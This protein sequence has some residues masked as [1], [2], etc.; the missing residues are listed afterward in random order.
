[1][2][3]EHP[4]IL[5]KYCSCDECGTYFGTRHLLKVH[6]EK[7]HSHDIQVEHLIESKS[8]ISKYDCKFYPAKFKYNKITRE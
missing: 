1:M 3:R 7:E 8:E 4:E 6:N 5:K 2:S